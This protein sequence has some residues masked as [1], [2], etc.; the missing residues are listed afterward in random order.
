MQRQRLQSQW[1]KIE[2][3]ISW[4]NGLHVKYNFYHERMEKGTTSKVEGFFS[5][6]KDE[7]DQGRENAY[8]GRKDSQ[9]LKPTQ[10]ITS[11]NQRIPRKSQITRNPKKSREK[12]SEKRIRTA[13]NYRGQCPN[14]PIIRELPF[15]TEVR[16]HML[17]V[18]GKT[19][20]GG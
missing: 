9:R 1:K 14:W 13:E 10:E 3:H 11:G 2:G 8:I 4:C 17:P 15:K 16:Y 19:Q 20:D 18:E 5:S 6:I 7:R 12:Y